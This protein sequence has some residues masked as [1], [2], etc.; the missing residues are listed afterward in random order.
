MTFKQLFLLLLLFFSNAA[1]AASPASWYLPQELSDKNTNIK[2]ELDSTWHTIHGI[3]SEVSGQAKLL[4]LNDPTSVSVKLEFPVIKM[5][6]DSESRDEEMMDVMDQEEFPKIYFEGQG[7]T[8]K[9]SPAKVDKYG[10]C[11]DSLNGTL[12]I[13]DVIKKV[14]LSVQILKADKS[15]LVKGTLP[16]NWAEFGVE[17][18]S[19]LIAS[20]D[21][22][23]KIQF[24]VVLASSIT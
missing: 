22:I 18:P 9:C 7:L 14:E 17:D 19:I 21:D 5:D 11:N 20:V 23:V 6:T 13:R 4:K 2:F 3:V 16:I 15:Y 1:F 12:K 10:A 24:E 8:N